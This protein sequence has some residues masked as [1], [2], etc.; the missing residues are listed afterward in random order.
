MALTP[1]DSDLLPMLRLFDWKAVQIL[2][3]NTFD[4]A[5]LPPERPTP[6]YETILI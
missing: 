3:R 6:V 1:L 2:T 4:R 5:S